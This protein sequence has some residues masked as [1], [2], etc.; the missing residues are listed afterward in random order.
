[1]EEVGTTILSERRCQLGEGPTYDPATDTAWWFDILER[2]LLQA[3]LAIGRRHHA[4]ASGDGQRA[5]R[6]R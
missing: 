1:M 6:H 2:T 5:G 4:R 3:D